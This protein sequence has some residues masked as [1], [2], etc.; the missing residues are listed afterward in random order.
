[1]TSIGPMCILTSAIARNIPIFKLAYCW[2]AKTY[3]GEIL[4]WCHN[5]GVLSEKPQNTHNLNGLFLNCCLGW[6]FK[7][8]WN[9]CPEWHGVG[10]YCI[11]L[12][13]SMSYIFTKQIVIQHPLLNLKGNYNSGLGSITLKSNRLRLQLHGF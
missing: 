4:I 11:N 12:S 9:D 6:I 5:D 13:T 10:H 7:N 1:M 8:C 3:T 2:N